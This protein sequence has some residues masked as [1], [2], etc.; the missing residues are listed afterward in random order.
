M[1]VCPHC[2]VEVAEE[3]EQCPHCQTWIERPPAAETKPSAPAS[4]GRK[5]PIAPKKF[6]TGLD[7]FLILVVPVVLA[8]V[9]VFLLFFLNIWNEWMEKFELKK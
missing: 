3:T 4:K 8:L 6:A 9:I 2:M 7:T 5:G 1:K